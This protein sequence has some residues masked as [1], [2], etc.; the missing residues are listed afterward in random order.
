[1]LVR[2]RSWDPATDPLRAAYADR[3]E[4]TL[5]LDEAEIAERVDRAEV[6]LGFPASQ[7]EQVARYRDDPNLEGRVFEAEISVF[8]SLTMNLAV[9]PFDDVHVRR[10]VARA[11]D[12]AAL[13]ELLSEP[14]H[15]PFGISWGEDGTHVAPDALEGQLLR[16]FDPYPYDPEAAQAEMRASTYDRTG[17]GRCDA[18]VCRNVRALVMDE[19]VLLDQAKAIRDDLAEIGIE[20]ELDPVPCAPPYCEFF[21]DAKLPLGCTP[22]RFTIPAAQIPLGF[23]TVG[24]DFPEG[25]GFLAA[26]RRVR[27]RDREERTRR[28]SGPPRAS[29]RDG[30]TP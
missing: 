26:V 1:M 14:P 17:D 18:A 2:N 9:P 21:G 20:L 24:A 10:A 11:I 16:A 3:I 4:L 5:G 15:G 7:F 23:A 29:S 25:A 13:V 30:D 28:S 8:W 6:D 19:G 12:R 22:A 27:A